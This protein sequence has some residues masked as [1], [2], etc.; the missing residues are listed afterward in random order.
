M[1][2]VYTHYE[3]KMLNCIVRTFAQRIKSRIQF[4]L[5]PIAV[6]HPSRFWRVSDSFRPRTGMGH[7]LSMR[8]GRYTVLFAA[9]F[10]LAPLI[11]VALMAVR[12][13]RTPPSL[14]G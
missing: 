8:G 4:A 10:P 7:G 9:V 11:G 6:L 3:E 14:Q 13:K 5:P 2:C 1:V 12:L